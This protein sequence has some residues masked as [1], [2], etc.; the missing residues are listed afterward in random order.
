MIAELVIVGL[1]AWRLAR[2]V[3]YEDGPLDVIQ[4][5]RGRAPDG[6]WLTLLTCPYCLSFW[7][8]AASLLVYRYL[9]PLPVVLVAAWGVAAL[10]EDVK[11]VL[12]R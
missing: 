10:I 9:D 4:S 6:F 8:G 7:T 5:I 3:V 12:V 11:S 1:A 2:L